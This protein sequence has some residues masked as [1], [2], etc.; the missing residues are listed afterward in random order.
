[1]YAAVIR[2]ITAVRSSSI[3]QKVCGQFLGLQRFL[4]LNVPLVRRLYCFYLRNIVSLSEMDV[5]DPA[6][7][8]SRVEKMSGK[9]PGPDHQP[10][11][12]SP[13]ATMASIFAFD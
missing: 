6:K 12:N 9:A 13:F 4:T 1:M 2:A 5:K 3:K 10:A 8:L 7:R 11:I